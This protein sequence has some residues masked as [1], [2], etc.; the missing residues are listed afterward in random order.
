V[1]QDKSNE[2]KLIETQV[3]SNFNQIYN[4]HQSEIAWKSELL[5]EHYYPYLKDFNDLK[6]PTVVYTH[7]EII[8]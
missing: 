2:E 6:A 5:Y 4:E 8:Q 3:N 7:K 1:F